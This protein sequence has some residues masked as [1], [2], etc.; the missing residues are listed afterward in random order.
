MG[1]YRI[2]RVDRNGGIT[3]TEKFTQR[4]EACVVSTESTPCRLVL[5]A[6]ESRG[7]INL[8]PIRCGIAAAA[9][10]T[11]ALTAQLEQPPERAVER[12][13]TGY[14]LKVA[15]LPRIYYLCFSYLSSKLAT[16]SQSQ[17]TKRQFS[18]N[19]LLRRMLF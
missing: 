10:A 6:I 1:K 16:Q 7:S 9:A 17:E 4:A 5:L 14:S 19:P 2:R 13:S 18:A 8:S 12:N 3:W 15:N 11:E